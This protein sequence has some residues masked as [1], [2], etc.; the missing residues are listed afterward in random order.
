MP[1]FCAAAAPDSINRFSDGSFTTPTRQEWALST[2]G[3]WVPHAIGEGHIDGMRE[4]TATD[5][6]EIDERTITHPGRDARQVSSNTTLAE[7]EAATEAEATSFSVTQHTSHERHS[8]SKQRARARQQRKEAAALQ[9]RIDAHNAANEAVAPTSSNLSMDNPVL[10]RVDNTGEAQVDAFS[11]L[12]H[13]VSNRGAEG[14]SMAFVTNNSVV[15]DLAVHQFGEVTMQPDGLIVEVAMLGQTGSST[16]SEGIGTIAAICI[17]GPAH[18][19]IDNATCLDKAKQLSIVAASTPAG[20]H[21]DSPFVRK[22][23]RRLCKGSLRRPWGLQKHGDIWCL[24]F[25]TILAKSPSSL[26]FAKVKGH[27]TNAHRSP[28]STP[29][30]IEDQTTQQKLHL[31]SSV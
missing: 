30:A 9:A 17:D 12:N 3:V 22:L 7:A 14:G 19:G 5:R 1:K 16:R 4:E 27:A 24:M 25:R 11:F 2:A 29:S 8:T 20:E 13:P 26:N 28:S 6:V 31:G 23:L 15:E 10:R 18:V 21:Y